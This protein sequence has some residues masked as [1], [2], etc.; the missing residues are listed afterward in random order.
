MF[1]SGNSLTS[2]PSEFFDLESLSCLSVRRNLITQIPHAIGRLHNLKEFNVA[3]N[4]LRWLPWELVG[5]VARGTLQSLYAKPNPL[6]THTGLKRRHNGVPWEEPLRIV[7]YGSTTAAFFELDGKLCKDSQPAPSLYNGEVLDTCST[8]VRPPLRHQAAG[9]TQSLFDIALQ[10]CIDS[11]ALAD[12][13]SYLPDET[14]NSVRQAVS[15]AQKVSEEGGRQCSVCHRRYVIARAEW[16]EYWFCVEHMND[17]EFSSFYKEPSN[18]LCT[19]P[20]LRRVCSWDCAAKAKPEDAYVS[21]SLSRTS[22]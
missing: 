9:S 14:P 1:L 21:H 6:I 2:V 4:Q 19:L 15:L 8:G 12:L 11:P 3:G 17:M 13:G 16:I 18:T 7:Y 10:A 22:T 5:L 20:F